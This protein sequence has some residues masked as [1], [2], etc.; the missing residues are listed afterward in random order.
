M[1]IKLFTTPT[2]LHRT[3]EAQIVSPVLARR[4]QEDPA[5]DPCSPAK[6]AT[7]YTSKPSHEY[8]F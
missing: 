6:S 5:S 4:R 8:V 7:L 3:Y 2:L 1:F